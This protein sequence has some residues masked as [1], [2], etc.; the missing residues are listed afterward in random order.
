MMAQLRDRGKCL[1]GSSARASRARAPRVCAWP[2][3]PDRNPS[4]APF[5]GP[6]E[7]LAKVSPLGHQSGSLGGLREIA[8]AQTNAGATDCRPDRRR[9]VPESPY[10]TTGWNWCAKRSRSM[11]RRG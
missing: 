5:A 9:V 10:A 6:D 2:R 11:M 1:S 8:P 3:S 4:R 7:V